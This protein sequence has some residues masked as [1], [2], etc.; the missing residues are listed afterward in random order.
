MPGHVSQKLRRKK[1]ALTTQQ[2]ALEKKLA[3]AITFASKKGEKDSP[4]I[5]KHQYDLNQTL[6]GIERMSV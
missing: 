5:R 3:G 6:K 2:L 1:D 4:E